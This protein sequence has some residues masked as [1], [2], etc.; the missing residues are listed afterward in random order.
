MSAPILEL[1]DVSLSFKG[2]RALNRLSFA[3]ARGEI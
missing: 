1:H 2:I 3:V